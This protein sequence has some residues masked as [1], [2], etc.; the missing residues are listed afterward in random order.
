MF[1]NIGK[2]LRVL[3]IVLAVLCFLGFAALGTLSLL[4]ALE[5]GLSKELKTAGLQAAIICYALSILTPF[6]NLV[7][8]GFG[9][10]ITAAQE[11][12]QDSKRIK[13]MLQSALADGMLSEEIARKSAQAQTKLLAHVMAKSATS[14]DKPQK[15]VRGPV[16]RLVSELNNGPEE[17]LAQAARPIAEEHPVQESSA[18]PVASEPVAEPV[19]APHTD[20]ERSTESS[21][22]EESVFAPAPA[23]IPVKPVTTTPVT[24]I[25]NATVLRPLS[26]DEETF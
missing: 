16:Q 26:G 10:L 14:A 15:P 6:L 7:L 20:E 9:T 25:A 11:Q 17:K 8:Y 2:T 18:S 12:A 13:E 3:A 24:P 22:Q 1:K 4:A 21:A 19:Q 23:F 5:K